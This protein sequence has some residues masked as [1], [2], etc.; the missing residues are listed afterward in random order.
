MASTVPVAGQL[1]AEAARVVKNSL[2]VSWGQSQEALV[3]L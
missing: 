3:L 1:R 2:G